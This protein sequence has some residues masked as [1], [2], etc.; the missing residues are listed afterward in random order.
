MKKILLI[1]SA[2]L[3][4]STSALADA[5]GEK[6]F[7]KCKSCHSLKEDKNKVGPSLYGLFGREAGTVEGYRYSKAMKN[8]GIVWDDR[9]LNVFIAKPKL[10]VPKT[11]M[12]FRGIRKEEDRK[13]VIEYLRGA[14]KLKEGE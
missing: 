2:L 5:H 11:R 8:S 6:V 7:R 13:A 9:I 12:S 10:T 3:L 14:T 4:I 1:V